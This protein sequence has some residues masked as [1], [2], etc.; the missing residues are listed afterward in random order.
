MIALSM[1][2]IEV[3]LAFDQVVCMDHQVAEMEIGLRALPLEE[4]VAA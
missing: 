3:A 2:E 1:I 4:E